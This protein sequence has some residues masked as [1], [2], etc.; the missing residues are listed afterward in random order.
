MI[1]FICDYD[2][3]WN[4]NDDWEDQSIEETLS[5]LGHGYLN[6]SL[7]I[8]FTE[9]LVLKIALYDLLENRRDTMGSDRTISLLYFMSF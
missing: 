2:T 1:V 9:N 3:A 7:D 8:H 6:A 4:D 5:G